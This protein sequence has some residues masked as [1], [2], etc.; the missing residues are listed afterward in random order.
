L[1]LFFLEANL[2]ATSFFQTHRIA[3]V[4]RDLW[5]SLCP[6]L[7]QGHPE[8]VA[9][10]QVQAGSEDLQRGDS[11]AFL[12]NMCQ[13]SITHTSTEVLLD[14]QTEPTTFQFMHTA[15]CP[16]SP[17]KKAW[18]CPLCAFSSGINIH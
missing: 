9:Q 4:Y 17:L 10:D 18:L 11:V 16:F 15:S 13:C 14:A 1:G 12:G 8:Q 3:D 2:N 7:K 6:L 5:R